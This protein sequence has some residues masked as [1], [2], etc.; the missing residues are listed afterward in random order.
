MPA[1]RRVA[2]RVM[3]I[4]KALLAYEPERIYLFGSWARGEADDMSD[5][6]LVLIKRTHRDFLDRLRDAAAFLPL[7]AGAV[8][9]LVYT[10]AEFEAMKKTGNAFA[11]MIAEEGVLVYGAQPES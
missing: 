8:D 3:K 6:D 4:V 1:T 9:L 11:Q 7:E 10:P 5:V 2:R